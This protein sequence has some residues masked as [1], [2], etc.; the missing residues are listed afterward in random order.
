[1]L[2]YARTA[3]TAARLETLACRLGFALLQ[4]QALESGAAQY[5]VLCSKAARGDGS[6]TATRLLDKAR[7]ETFGTTI[8]E[9]KKAGLLSEALE[10]RFK[11]LLKERNWLVH[12]SR[13]DNSAALG[14]DD[15]ALAMMNRVN[16][17]ADESVLLIKEIAAL[18]TTF[19]L[20]AGI[21][22][23]AVDRATE[24][25]MHGWEANDAI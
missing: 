18:S 5:L 20:A 22:Q 12:K 17:I 1:M 4:V 11:V 2:P 10:V 8:G 21:T 19:V 9:M 7:K 15:A 6:E 3:E 16:G 25:L 14:S 24:E 13:S 23:E